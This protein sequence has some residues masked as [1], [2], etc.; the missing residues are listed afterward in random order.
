MPMMIPKVLKAR[1]ILAA[2]A[3]TVESEGEGF[4]VVVAVDDYDPEKRRRTA[5]AVIAKIA[6]AVAVVGKCGRFPNR[7]TSVQHH[8]RWRLCV[9][10][11]GHR[12]LIRVARE[13][14]NLWKRRRRRGA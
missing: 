3:A 10:Q 2:A 6:A 4:V 7:E 14:E 11:Q 13:E 8:L 9:L 12:R 5:G 1:E